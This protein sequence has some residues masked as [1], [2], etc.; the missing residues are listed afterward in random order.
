MASQL[1]G[2]LF[3]S[4]HYFTIAIRR[5]TEANILE[6]ACF[7]SEHILPAGLY[8]WVA[9]PILVDYQGKT[10]LFYEAVKGDKGRIEVAEVQD[11]CTLGKRTV[12]LEDEYHYSYPFVFRHEDV[13]YMIPESSA[14]QEV[15]L[16]QAIDFPWK[17]EKKQ[18]LLSGFRAVDTTAFSQDGVW[19]LLTYLPTDKTE[20]VTPRAYQLQLSGEP[21]LTE[22]PWP[23][24]D[25][26][27]VRGAGPVFTAGERQY[28]PAQLSEPDCYGNAVSFF[29]IA[30]LSPEY[31]EV[32]KARLTPAQLKLP[33][34]ICDGLHTYAVSGK[35]E[36][37]DIR[38]RKVEPLKIFRKI[39]QRIRKS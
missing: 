19:Y 17:W 10:F 33:H 9:D 30:T 18:I 35:F 12:I 34:V 36:A 16:Y 4:A 24:F 32:L 28:R 5:R 23:E 37:I 21:G 15:A 13:W 31:R 3:L 20:H 7:Q 29:E 38:C 27:E 8:D 26:L 6:D 1:L 2:K 14:R 25:P 11:D 39:I 22:I